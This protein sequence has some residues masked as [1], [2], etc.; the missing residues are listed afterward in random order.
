LSGPAEQQWEI[1]RLEIMAE[2]HL[3]ELT[4]LMAVVAVAVIIAVV[5]VVAVAEGEAIAG[6]MALQLKAM[7]AL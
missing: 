4:W 5:T 6:T 2:I 1:Q 3:L 7:P